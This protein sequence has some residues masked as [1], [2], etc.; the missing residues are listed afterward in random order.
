M[1]DNVSLPFELSTESL[2]GWVNSLNSLPAANAANQLNLVLKHLTRQLG[3]PATKMLPLLI[4]LTPLTFHLANGLSHT[5]RSEPN[6]TANSRAL[7]IAKLSIQLLR[8]LGLD[9]CRLVETRQLDAAQ[10]QHAIFYALQLIGYSLRASALFYEMP[11]ATLWKKSGVLYT[12]A[13][14]QRILDQPISTK[15]PEFKHQA[16]INAVIKRN[17]LFAISAPNRYPFAEIAALFQLAN[18]FQDRLTI[19]PKIAPDHH[20]FWNLHS[21]PCPLPRPGNALP[22]GAISISSQ[23]IGHALQLGD[24]TTELGSIMQTRLA[25]HLSAY[26]GI[27]SSVTIGPPM[28]AHLLEGFVAVSEHLQGEEKL[29]KIMHLSGQPAPGRSLAR[30]M[31]LI[32]LEHQKSYYKP[33]NSSIIS[34]PEHGTRLSLLRNPSKQFLVAETTTP[35]CATGDIGLLCREQQPAKLVL[36]RQQTRHDDITLILLELIVGSVAIFDIEDSNQQKAIVIGTDSDHPEIILASGKYAV[37]AKLRLL[38]GRSLQ[39]TSCV[40][41]TPWIVRFK[42]GF[43]S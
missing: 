12:I 5:A 25:L 18:H 8:H 36:V 15:Q 41:S 34:F 33:L 28:P 2:S 20:F 39:L 4:M 11:S 29:S 6:L 40:E 30:D 9:F 21:E 7:K 13:G 1:T 38:Y 26:K 10:N 24:I 32:P 27:F 16:T 17:I 3:I 43:D 14:E 22:N 31:S 19:A 35:N 23:A 42:I 37:G